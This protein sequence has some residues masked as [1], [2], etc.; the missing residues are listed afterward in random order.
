MH[1]NLLMTRQ[2]QTNSSVSNSSTP[3]THKKPRYLITDKSLVFSTDKPFI[4]DRKFNIVVYNIDKS[5]SGIVR[6]THIR[7]TVK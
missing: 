3:M 2:I 1:L 4:T 7:N 6:L 5:S